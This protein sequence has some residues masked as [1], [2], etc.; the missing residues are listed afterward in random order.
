ML[1][2]LKIRLVAGLAAC[3]CVFGACGFMV[4]S[5]FAVANADAVEESDNPSVTDVTA[6]FAQGSLYVDGFGKC[7]LS[8]VA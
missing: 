5:G 7:G 1:K 8:R 3:A 6:P 2:D 4:Q